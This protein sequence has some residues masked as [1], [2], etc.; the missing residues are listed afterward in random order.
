MIFRKWGGGQRPVGTF[1]KIHPFWSC[2]AS[3]KLGSVTNCCITAYSKNCSFNI[4]FSRLWNQISMFFCTKRSGYT[5]AG[6][7]TQLRLRAEFAAICAS[8]RS[9]LTHQVD[10]DGAMALY[11]LFQTLNQAITVSQFSFH[12]WCDGSKKVI[13]SPTGDL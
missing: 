8:G 11:S 2:Q 12:L 6:W 4:L 10:R 13:D 3:L 5:A 1:P 7:D 9:R